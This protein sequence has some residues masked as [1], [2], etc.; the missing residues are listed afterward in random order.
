MAKAGVRG[1]TPNRLIQHPTRLFELAEVFEHLA[2]LKG[3]ERIGISSLAFDSAL[4]GCACAVP[5]TD[6]HT[7][8]TEI[9]ED[10]RRSRMQFIGPLIEG[11][12]G[13]EFPGD[14]LDTPTYTPDVV[15]VRS[16]LQ[17]FLTSRRH[18]HSA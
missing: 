5:I 6:A 8:L 4:K 3:E 2:V 14:V 15:I 7:G 16:L 1:I 17:Q 11:D 13:I 12:R 10:R 18:R 9:A